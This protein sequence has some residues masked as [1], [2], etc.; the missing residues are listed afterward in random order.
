[1]EII[2]LPQSATMGYD[3]SWW[4]GFEGEITVIF[5]RKTP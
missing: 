5:L 1:M 4:G 3:L 2:S